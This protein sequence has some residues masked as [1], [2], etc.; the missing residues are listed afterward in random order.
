MLG[1][2]RRALQ[3][4]AHLSRRVADAA[5]GQLAV[6]RELYN[7]S[8]EERR[9]HWQRHGVT[10][11]A[12]MQSKQLPAI[13]ADRADVAAVGSQVL[14]DVI[15]RVDKAFQAFFRRVKAGQT[16][17]YP[18]FKPRC[19][20]TSLTF[21]QCGWSLGPVS[22]SGTKRT[23]TLHGIGAL[24]L[25]WSRDLEGRVKT[26][27]LKRDRC[28]DWWVTFSCDDV[29]ARLLPDTGAEIG[30]D[31]GLEFFLSKSEGTPIDNPRPMRAASH[32]LAQ[33]QRRKDKRTKGG[34]RRRKAVRHLA[35]HHR[36]AERVRRDFHH[37]TA[38]D[39]VRQYDL[40]AVEDLN[41]RGLAR[42]MLAKSVHDAGW[43][44][45]IAILTDKA[46]S[47]GRSLMAVDPRGTSQMCSACG[48]VPAVP[49]PLSQR[50]HR[51]LCG[52][53]AHRDVNAAR[54]ILARARAGPSAS[55]LAAHAAAQT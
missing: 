22:A 33:S 47:A 31:L 28:G 55:G 51:C 50:W 42:G 13:K 25:H 19:Q 41:V 35:K 15:Q 20:Y 2:M 3:Y 49:K 45:F 18:R 44:Q 14:Q 54:N 4:K 17:G 37:K 32:R 53:A 11:T 30:L 40:I 8:L 52:Y 10:I 34:M 36:T 46:A 43:A 38:R 29:P 12:A 48:L 27:T 24:R 23:I 9:G 6:C 5:R 21:K 7:A 26:V 39:L 16:P 1:G